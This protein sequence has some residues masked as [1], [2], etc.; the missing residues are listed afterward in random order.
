MKWETKVSALQD[1]D[2]EENSSISDYLN[3]N[4]RYKFM[5]WKMFLTVRKLVMYLRTVPIRKSGFGS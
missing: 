5:S 3:K 4:V 2:L 1:R